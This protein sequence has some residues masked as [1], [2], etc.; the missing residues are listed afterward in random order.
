MAISTPAQKPLGSAS[1]TRSTSIRAEATQLPCPTDE[2]R[3]AAGGTAAGPDRRR[4][5]VAQRDLVAGPPPPDRR[6]RGD[7]HVVRLRGAGR[8]HDH[9]GVAAD[10][11][12]GG[13]GAAFSAFFLGSVVGVLFG[14]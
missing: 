9:A 12:R 8:G 4:G 7:D 3:P 2:R 14:G 5:H 10:L 13:Y 1:S 11:G 6:P